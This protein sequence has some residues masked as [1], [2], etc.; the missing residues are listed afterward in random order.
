M[1]TKAY[2]RDVPLPPG[3]PRAVTDSATV[4][5]MVRALSHPQMEGRGAGT[6]GL[7]AAADLIAG[8]MRWLGLKPGGDDGT[9]FQR[10]EVTTGVAVGEPSA[11]AVGGTRFPVGDRFQPLGFSTNGTL[12]APVVFAGY[13]ITAPGYEW[14]D[15]AGLD[16][17]D[18]L[19]LVLSQEP[20][21][22]DSTSR[23]DGS[24]NT[25]YAE[26]R[27]KAITAREHGAAIDGSQ[28]CHE[29]LSQQSPRAAIAGRCSRPPSSSPRAH[30]GGWGATRGWRC[31]AADRWSRMSSSVSRRSA[32]RWRSTALLLCARLRWRSTL[33]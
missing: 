15:Y 20:G 11:I 13:G 12:R 18:K 10:F 25:P 4:M 33:P 27:T 26:L 16:V 29:P 6:A 21:E 3:R 24:V 22:M 23:M 7:D 2:D 31:L 9:Y 30:R 32:G 28:R 8:E 5:Y 14:D 19:V 1:G 17:R